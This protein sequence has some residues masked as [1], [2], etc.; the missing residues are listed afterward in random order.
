MSGP[1]G[2]IVLQHRDGLGP[3]V[4]IIQ[5]C[6]SNYGSLDGIKMSYDSLVRLA[7]EFRLEKEVGL[8]LRCLSAASQIQNLDNLQ[9]ADVNLNIGR[10]LL[11]YGKNKGHGYPFNNPCYVKK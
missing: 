4:Y 6:V 5:I 7:E 2:L 9:K 11:K 1:Y 8:A 3:L 10:L